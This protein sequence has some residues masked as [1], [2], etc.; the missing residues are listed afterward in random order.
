MKTHL[1]DPEMYIANLRKKSF[2]YLGNI[3]FEK[4]KHIVWNK[5]QLLALFYQFCPP[6]E[7][8]QIELN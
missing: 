8:T 2:P 1:A 7:A 5:N 3:L 6:T 4:S